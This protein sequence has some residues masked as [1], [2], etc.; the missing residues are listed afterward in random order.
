MF[1]T[2]KTLATGV[3]ILALGTFGA[4]ADGINP[5]FYADGGYIDDIEI[6]G[7]VVMSN[8]I[9]YA[10]LEM[11]EQHLR[12]YV[13]P[14]AIYVTMLVDN[15]ILTRQLPFNGFWVSTASVDYTGLT[16]CSAEIRDESGESYPAHGSVVWTNSGIAANGYEL[17]FTIDL[18]T[19]DR[20]VQPWGYSA[21][22]LDMTRQSAVPHDDITPQDAL[23]IIDA[24]GEAWVAERDQAFT[25]L[26]SQEARKI[27]VP[28]AVASSET[29]YEQDVI[30]MQPDCLASS[31]RRGYGTWSWANGGFIVEFDTLRLAFPRTDA[32]IDNNGGCR[33]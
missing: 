7:D 9:E 23:T 26:I 11:R 31:L 18:G 19:C 32:P 12:F 22:A 3:G 30:V 16:V 13:D 15:P 17:A 2:I 20:P 10:V 33:M 29:F 14:D 5:I 21:A 6:M 4:H 27:V 25:T 28:T 24:N 8:G 1:G